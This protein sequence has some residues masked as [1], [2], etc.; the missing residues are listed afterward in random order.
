MRNYKV[1]IEFID[2][3]SGKNQE[4]GKVIEITSERAEAINKAV[5]ESIGEEP[6]VVLVEDQSTE[7]SAPKK[8][9]RSKKVVTKEEDVE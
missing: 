2:R 9:S 4:V 7:E 1:Q 5:F 8:G 6:A 3:Y